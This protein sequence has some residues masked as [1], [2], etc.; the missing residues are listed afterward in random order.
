MPQSIPAGLTRDHV[1][2]TL[3]DIDAGIDHPFGNPTG[4]E[5][6]CDEMRSSVL[7][8]GYWDCSAWSA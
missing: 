4:Y 7:N 8:R 1:L 5:P 2:K 3:A 6:I